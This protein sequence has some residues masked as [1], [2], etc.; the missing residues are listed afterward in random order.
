MKR[1]QSCRPGSCARL[2]GG[3]A[4]V[5]FLITGI[6]VLIPLFILI[7]TL[8]KYMDAKQKVEVAARYAAWE[9]TVW[10]AG[11]EGW[12]PVNTV[13]AD[14]KIQAE[15]QARTFTKRET[16]LSSDAVAIME[17]ADID[18][19]LNYHYG[20]SGRYEPILRIR[21]GA[22]GEYV[23]ATTVKHEA[24]GLAGEL[25]E[26][27]STLR[28]FSASDQFD[29]D[30]EGAHTATVSVGLLNPRQA[31]FAGVDLTLERSVTLVTDNW[32]AGGP[33][34]THRR[35]EGL[36]PT[37]ILGEF[38]DIIEN[39]PSIP[40]PLGML[41]RLTFNHIDVDQVPEQYLETYR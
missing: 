5:E 10:H 2:S 25:T 4:L 35:I 20:E 18:P 3:Q 39:L 19:L 36:M 14:S 15:A 37:E 33:D 34:H 31:E 26:A 28:M 6:L 16:H 8:G 21:P 32:N 7:V 13:K 22:L 12:L 17:N 27:V 9:R 24:P 38:F 23:S 41:D 11:N 30:T 29:I 1:H 40:G